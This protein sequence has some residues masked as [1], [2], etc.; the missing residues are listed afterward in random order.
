MVW[1]TSKAYQFCIR[2]IIL[3]SLPCFI[4][5]YHRYHLFV[6]KFTLVLLFT[7]MW[8]FFFLEEMEKVGEKNKD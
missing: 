6:T 5:I 7:S 2:S 1:G 3:L 8:V 4:S